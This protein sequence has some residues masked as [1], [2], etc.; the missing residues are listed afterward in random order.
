MAKAAKKTI[1]R[2]STRQIR[3]TNVT[4]VNLTPEVDAG[5]DLVC[6]YTGHSKSMYI[7]SLI[8]ENLMA[9]GVLARPVPPKPIEVA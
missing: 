3:L 4:S 5:I 9:N 2:K 1:K 7:R 6:K 8:V